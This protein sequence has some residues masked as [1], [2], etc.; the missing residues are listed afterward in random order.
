MSALNAVDVRIVEARLKHGTQEEAARAAGVSLRTLQRRLASPAVRQALADAA[1]SELRDVT[2]ELSRH[3]G[4]AVEVLAKMSDGSIPAQGARVK[5]AAAIVSFALRV[6]EVDAA[7]R[8]AAL[9]E[10]RLSP[11]D[12][13]GGE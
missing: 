12:L 6:R 9:L 8:I 10:G 2:V 7:D 1:T 5:A 11:E 13:G 3:A 4:G